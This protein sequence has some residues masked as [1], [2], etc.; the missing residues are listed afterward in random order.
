[1][2]PFFPKIDP[3]VIAN[4]TKAAA[5]AG[6][7]AARTAR[8]NAGVNDPV[9]KPTTDLSGNVKSASAVAEDHTKTSQH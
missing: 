6:E 9:K 8:V 4:A 2:R 7:N 5:N 3:A 1:M